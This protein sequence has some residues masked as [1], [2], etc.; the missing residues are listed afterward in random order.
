M[1]RGV[2]EA[3]RQHVRASSECKLGMGARVAAGRRR[4][5]AERLEQHEL[6]AAHVPLALVAHREGA[7]QPA[8]PAQ[9]NGE[10]T[11]REPRLAARHDLS[12]Q[13]LAQLHGLA[14]PLGGL[15]EGGARPD[16]VRTSAEEYARA[17]GVEQPRRLLA[18]PHEHPAGVEALV[19]AADCIQ[20][21]RRAVHHG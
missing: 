1:H 13:T 7:A 10:R 11:I 15:P 14:D 8:V 5:V 6:L 12:D 18:D 16:A 17:V 4:E 20:E 3:A 9:R 2:V 19:Q 21:T